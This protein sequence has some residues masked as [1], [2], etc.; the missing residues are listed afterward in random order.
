MEQDIYTI[1]QSESGGLL[2]FE[3]NKKLV[4]STRDRKFLRG[5][6]IAIF[7]KEDN[8]IIK[9]KV[10]GLFRT[11]YNII[12]QQ[13]QTHVSLKS[14]LL[15]KKLFFNDSVL[16]LK[17]NPIPFSSKKFAKLY[18]D[19]EIIGTLKFFQ[20]KEGKNYELRLNKGLSAEIRTYA[21]ILILV[22]ETIN[23]PDDAAGV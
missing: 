19:D 5:S 18:N 12:E 20:F 10:S 3:G 14:S 4:Y 16:S 9:V 21:M 8:L 2:V 15:N 11:F 7:D 22:H 1:T 17:L 23:E 13:L 6:Y